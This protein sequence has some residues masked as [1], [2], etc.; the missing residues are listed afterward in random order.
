[1]SILRVRVAFRGVVGVPVLDDE[2]W[3]NIVM[4]NAFSKRCV[5]ELDFVRYYAARLCVVIDNTCN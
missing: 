5:A 3:R 4:M 1:M 2:A